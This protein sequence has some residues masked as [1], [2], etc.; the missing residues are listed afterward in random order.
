MTV[1]RRGIVK[2]DAGVPG[3]VEHRLGG[4]LVDGAKDVAKW[5]RSET[6]GG[7]VD[8][9]PTEFALFPGCMLILL[10]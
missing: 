7:H 9:D 4:R 3:R 5:R 10:K 6:E 1:H 8:V 2:P